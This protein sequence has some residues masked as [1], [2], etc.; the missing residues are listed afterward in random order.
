MWEVNKAQ[1]PSGSLWGPVQG[2]YGRNNGLVRRAKLQKAAM[3]DD[4]DLA[5][6]LD[7][8]PAAANGV[9][10]LPDVEREWR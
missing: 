2:I 5:A 10:W 7:F 3:L 4:V 8:L 1:E 6:V 9:F